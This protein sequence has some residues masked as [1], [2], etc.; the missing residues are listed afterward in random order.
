MMAVSFR[1][2]LYCLNFALLSVAGLL[3]SCI[4]RSEEAMIM[5]LVGGCSSR[6]LQSK[7][8]LG[9]VIQSVSRHAICERTAFSSTD[10]ATALKQCWLMLMLSTVAWCYAITQQSV[11]QH[12]ARTKLYSP[13]RL[14]AVINF[15]SSGSPLSSNKEILYMLLTYW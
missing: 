10:G 4:T 1:V 8:L 15:S 12:R 6:L 7:P 5:V 3:S 14:S 13:L 9:L 11:S 2:I